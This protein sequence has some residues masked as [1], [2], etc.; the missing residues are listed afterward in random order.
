M[1]ACLSL[2]PLLTDVYLN[3]NMKT[4]VQRRT[5]EKLSALIIKS[6]NKNI[7][8]L[9]LWN[10]RNREKPT[11]KRTLHLKIIVLG[12]IHFERTKKIEVSHSDIYL[13]SPP[14][15]TAVLTLGSVTIGDT[16]LPLPWGF[17]FETSSE[18]PAC[19]KS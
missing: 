9:L 8:S 12:F 14:C 6:V 4:A 18:P 7:K 2:N 17:G 16:E 13:E 11:Q 15:H 5:A 3:T 10:S 19:C 1:D